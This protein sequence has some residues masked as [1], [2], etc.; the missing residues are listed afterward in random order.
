MDIASKIHKFIKENFLSVSKDIEDTT[1]FLETGAVDSTGILEIIQF[2]EETFGITVQDEELVPE[3][4]D[5]FENL[6]NFVKRKLEKG[7]PQRCA[8]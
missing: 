3:N 4:L 2:L 5:S 8:V 7:Q 1:S 6:T